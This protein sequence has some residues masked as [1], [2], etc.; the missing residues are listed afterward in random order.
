MATPHYPRWIVDIATAVV[1]VLGTAN[2]VA[3]FAV[4]DY[5]P[6]PLL[7][8]LFV[9]VVGPVVGVRIVRNGGS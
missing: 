3:A 4:E 2:F 6:D 9:A 1:F 7:S 5:R 8:G